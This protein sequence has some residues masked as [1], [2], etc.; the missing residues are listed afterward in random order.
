MKKLAIVIPVYNEEDNIKKVLD[1]WKIILSRNEF[2]IIVVN[3]GSLDKT[4]F[5]LNKIKKNNNHIK[6]LNKLN[7]G[8]G[9]SV[10]FGYKYAV[11]KNYQFIFQVDSDD[12]FSS[13][14]FNKLWK[15]RNKDYDL[16]LGC[17]ENRKDPI[18]RIFLSKIILRFFFIIFFQKYISDANT[19]YRLIKNKFLKIFL[20]NCN[21]KYLAPNILMSLFA[22]KIIPINVKHLQRSKGVIKWPVKKLIFFG[23][24]LI[25]EIIKFRKIISKNY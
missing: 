15:I 13:L 6:I 20:N 17:R 11:K 8:H 5:I 25:I 2:D 14:D 16:I 4:N 7:G 10:L 18:I 3:D 21:K 12:Q 22:K 24:K 1:D 9:D 19:P 23:I